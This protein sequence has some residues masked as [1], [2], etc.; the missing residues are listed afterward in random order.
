MQLADALRLSSRPVHNY[1]SSLR[2]TCPA[3]AYALSTPPSTRRLRIFV[4]LRD[5]L[6]CDFTSERCS[7]LHFCGPEKCQSHRLQHP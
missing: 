6:T 3:C 2:T 4:D 7:D 1:F 5:A